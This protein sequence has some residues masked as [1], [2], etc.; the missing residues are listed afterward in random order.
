MTIAFVRYFDS[1]EKRVVAVFG[2]AQDP[3][4]YPI[5]GEIDSSDSRYAAFISSLPPSAMNFAP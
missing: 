2:C 3:T 1:T 4:A 5:L